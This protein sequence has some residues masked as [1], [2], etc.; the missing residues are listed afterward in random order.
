M[1]NWIRLCWAVLL[2]GSP[3]ALKADE[4]LSFIT[5]AYPPYNFSDDNILR[6]IAVDLLVIA[7]QDTA[8]PVQRGQIRLMPWARGYRTVLSTPN[9]V[10]FATTRTAERERLFKWAGPIAA[11]RVVLLARKADK[12]RIQSAAD[13]QR[14]RIGVIHE[15]IGEQSLLALG[16]AKQQLQI[17][18]NADALSR[19]LHAGRI[20]LWAY[21]ENVAR[22]FLRN[23]N[24]DQDDFE[25]VYLLQQGE[26]W[27]A[28]NP[29]VSDEKIQQLQKALDKLR[30]TP[31][32]F[33]QTRYDD[34]LINYL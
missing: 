29:Q 26:L 19:Q 23:A 33:A 27:Y 18:A 22:W 10:L 8:Q 15:D 25:S 21:E 14:Y 24:L 7:S 32:K 34:I 6:G 30:N 5:E 13:L 17:S 1:G 12:I 31:G 11:I 16:V 9:T 3:L 28:F 20:D 2:L 4:P